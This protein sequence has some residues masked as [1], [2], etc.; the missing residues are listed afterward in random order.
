MSKIRAL[1]AEDN[2][3]DA[4][5]VARE[6]RTVATVDVA[7]DRN[8]FL[9]ML[10]EPWDVAL[11]DLDMGDLQGNEAIAMV[12][13]RYPSLPVIIVTGSVSPR[14]ADLACNFGAS[15]F[16]MKEI[17]GVPGLARAVAEAHETAKLKAQ[18]LRDQRL[19]QLGDHSVGIVHDFNGVLQVVMMGAEHL[20]TRINPMDEHILDTMMS[21][22]KRGAEMTAQVLA[23]ARGTNGSAFKALSPAYLLTEVGRFVRTTFPPTIHVTTDTL[24][25]TSMI[26]GD[27]TQ[28]LQVLSNLATN[29]RDSMPKGGTLRFKAQNVARTP[30]LPGP[31][32]VISVS[33]TGCGIPKESLGRIWE[34][35]FTSKP[36]GQ[37]T[38]LGLPTVKRIV[39]AHH[40]VVKV[41]TGPDGTT[42]Y[43]HLPVALPWAK[44]EAEPGAEALDGKGRTVLLVDDQASF[45]DLA[46]AL[47]EHA[48]YHVVTASN[49]PEALNFFRVGQTID[50][51][52][53]DLSMS[54]MTGDDLARNLRSV[55][56]TL[57]IVYLSGFDATLPRDPVPQATLQKPVNRETLLSTLA[58]VLTKAQAEGSLAP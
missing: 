45:R 44:Q 18:S 34:P 8:S 50:V 17:D 9:R 47:L 21:A 1:L 36:V 40:G 29:A 31:C 30:E 52:V 28:L 24:P 16:F 35:F 48:G 10:D 56:L 51:L 26:K 3:N 22:A 15:R 54:P 2:P 46:A 37:G 43:V 23:F 42:F 38:G 53:T 5:I 39:E 11:V 49:G 4:M 41:L 33:D 55:G 13:E 12:K 6:V 19:E 32:V 7:I 25:G 58:K 20:R 57:P 14:Q 27:A